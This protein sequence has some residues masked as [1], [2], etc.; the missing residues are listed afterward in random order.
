M[1]DWEKQREKAHNHFWCI[2]G[3]TLVGAGGC[4]D[5][6]GS[7]N[8]VLRGNNF[9]IEQCKAYC[10]NNRNECK[11]IALHT[12]SGTHAG[13]CYSY[14]FVA[15]TL[16]TSIDRDVYLSY[17]AIGECTPPLINQRPWSFVSSALSHS[18]CSTGRR[19]VFQKQDWQLWRSCINRNERRMQFCCC[20]TQLNRHCSRWPLIVLEQ[21]VWMLLQ[22]LK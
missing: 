3:Y 9:N 6:L 7:G 1:S 20:R 4:R 12:G 13:K 8:G 19:D 10:N 11:S 18:L 5:T 2:T 21:S 22:S 15:M 17:A 14:D 16:D